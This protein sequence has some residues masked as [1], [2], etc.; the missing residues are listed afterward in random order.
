MHAWIPHM[1]AMLGVWV[2]SGVFLTGRSVSLTMLEGLEGNVMV[3]FSFRLRPCRGIFRERRFCTADD[4]PPEE[5]R[6]S[7][8]PS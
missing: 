7:A 4:E 1:L 2:A 6:F 8:L 3:C 5:C